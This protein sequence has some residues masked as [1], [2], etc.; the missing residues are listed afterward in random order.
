MGKLTALT[1]LVLTEHNLVE[2]PIPHE[3]VNLTHLVRLDLS[4][5]SL[6]GPI[7]AELFN[8][9][10]LK[11]LFLNNNNLRGPIPPEL[12]TNLSSLEELVLTEHNLVEGPIPHCWFELVNSVPLTHLADFPGYGDPMKRPPESAISEGDLRQRIVQLEQIVEQ[13]TALAELERELARRKSGGPH[14]DP[15]GARPA[16]GSSTGARS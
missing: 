9:R 15:R 8:L 7:P 6:V 11:W 16:D 5:N 4:G 13:Q 1:E 10:E 3:L 14:A 2:G 12:F